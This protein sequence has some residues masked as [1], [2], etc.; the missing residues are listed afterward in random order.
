MYKRLFLL[1]EGNDDERFFDKIIKPVM[2]EKYDYVELWKHS[3]EPTKRILD[4]IKSIKQMN[5][6]YIY[7]EDMDEI[8]SMTKKKQKIMDRINRIDEDNIII[9]K[10]EIESWYLSGLDN[11]S[12]KKCGI[13]SLNSTDKITKETFND[14]IPRRFDSRN[15][16]M[17]EILKVF[18]L[19]IAKE[20][21]QSIKYFIDEIIN[22]E[23]GNLLNMH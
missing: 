2:N 7:F 6:K 13:K 12:A 18:S 14:L 22:G 16:F 23:Q 4:F 11:K 3:Q 21:N 8:P 19:D 1:I 17:V 20:K 15:V 9:V 10:K 5:A